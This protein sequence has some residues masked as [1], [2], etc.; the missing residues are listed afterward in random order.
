MLNIIRKIRGVLQSSYWNIG[1]FEEDI[2][3]VLNS[4]HFHIHWLHHPYKDRWF[5]DPFFLRVD[6]THIVL[7]AEEFCYA[8]KKGRIAKLVIKRE[9]Y[10]LEEMKIILELPSH[11][12]FPFIYWKDGSVYIIPESSK[13]G[14][15]DV[16]AYHEETD[17]VKKISTL[18]H[19]PL[20]DAVLIDMPD[21]REYVLSTKEPTQNK[22]HLQVYSVD[23]DIWKMD[24]QPI[25]DIC[26]GSNIAR[27]A[28]NVFV[29]DGVM[30]R[31]AQDCNKGYGNGVVI[32]QMNYANGQFSLK[33]VRT[34][35]SDIP[36]FDMGYH[37]FNRM[38]GLI[39]VDAHGHRYQM[40]NQVVI[41][42]LKLY[43]SIVKGGKTA[44]K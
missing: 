30:Y 2:K 33:D 38:N 26:F 13:S 9:G 31:P 6:D 8:S 7:L 22:N 3:E 14:Q 12:S 24:E 21:G 11:L 44:K 41:I 5:A 35:F 34:F 10:L 15:T 19:L 42:L 17:E 36:T 28:G 37:T 4:D 32:Q 20:T 27:N 1:F 29:V 43:R 16:Y 23:T 18:C 40:A 39:V 25:Q